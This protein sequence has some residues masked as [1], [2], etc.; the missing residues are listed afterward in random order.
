MVALEAGMLGLLIEV[1]LGVLRTI[2]L[3]WRE[4]PHIPEPHCCSRP[5]AL[6]CRCRTFCLLLSDLPRRDIAQGAD[7]DA[8]GVSKAKMTPTEALVELMLLPMT[9]T[10]TPNQDAGGAGETPV[11]HKDIAL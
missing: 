7:V 6:V 8:G 9:A 2:K 5:T 3:G 1:M 10:T 11:A 4:V